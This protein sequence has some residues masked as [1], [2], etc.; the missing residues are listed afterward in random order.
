MFT[1]ICFITIWN[2]NTNLFNVNV[3]TLSC[4]FYIL[5][6]SIIYVKCSCKCMATIRSRPNTQFCLLGLVTAQYLLWN[7]DSEGFES[8]VRV[9]LCTR[10]ELFLKPQHTCYIFF[11]LYYGKQKQC[12]N[13]RKRKSARYQSR[14]LEE[15][16]SAPRM[17]H[18]GSAKQLKKLQ[19]GGLQNTK[20]WF[21]RPLKHVNGH[22]YN[23]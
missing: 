20:Q 14:W 1:R 21:Q 4:I 7:S 11:S 18:R 8:H 9:M 3:F 17:W 6:Y 23:I 2:W 16:D 19:V 5:F 13:H 12:H 15:R 22:Q 10:Y